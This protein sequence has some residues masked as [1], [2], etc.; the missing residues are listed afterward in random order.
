[1]NNEPYMIIE[2]WAIPQNEPEQKGFRITFADGYDPCSLGYK[3]SIPDRCIEG[4]LFEALLLDYF[5]Q[6]FYEWVKL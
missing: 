3:S 6:H 2:S 1:M 4:P 5:R